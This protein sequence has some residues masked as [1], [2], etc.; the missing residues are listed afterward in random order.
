MIFHFIHFFWHFFKI[1]FLQGHKQ[2]IKLT[3]WF[4]VVTHCV[5]FKLTR[6]LGSIWEI[7]EN[8]F[9]GPGRIG[10]LKKQ[11]LIRFIMKT[12]RAT[13]AKKISNMVRKMSVSHILIV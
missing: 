7:E 9:L 12:C 8:D 6:Q 3:W 1:F 2:T 13:N 10:K 5:G 11:H 4:K